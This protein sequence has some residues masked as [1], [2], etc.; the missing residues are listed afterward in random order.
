MFRALGLFGPKGY[1]APPHGNGTSLRNLR[2]RGTVRTPAIR[3]SFDD[4]I[5]PSRHHDGHRSLFRLWQ[6]Q[7]L[8][9]A[10]RP[11]SGI[12]WQTPFW[13][14]DGQAGTIFAIPLPQRHAGA[15][16]RHEGRI[17]QSVIVRSL[18]Q[19]LKAMGLR[20][21]TGLHIGAPCAIMNGSIST[22]ARKKRS[23]CQVCQMCIGQMQL[24]NQ[25]RMLNE[26]LVVFRPGC[27]KLA[28]GIDG[29]QT[30]RVPTPSE[31]GSP[32]SRQRPV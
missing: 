28:R 6:I 10:S 3:R 15:T 27:R 18:Q 31:A 12:A 26:T 21:P 20:H 32:L 25:G 24:R 17:N 16:A 8:W 30:N 13:I 5:N 2:L 14:A 7:P 29:R 1:A 11:G 22:E 4:E 9:A 23:V 19:G